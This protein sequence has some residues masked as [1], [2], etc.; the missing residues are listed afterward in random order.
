MLYKQKHIYGSS[1]VGMDVAE[2]NMISTSVTVQSFYCESGKKQYELS[3]HLGNVL[4]VITDKKIPIENSLV[5]GE[6]AYFEA[7][8]LTASD[9]SPFG[10]I[11]ENRDYTSEKY[12]YGF[13]NQERDDELKDNGNS[14][15][16][17]YR[18]HDPRL[19]RFFSVDPVSNEYPYNSC[20]AFSEN[21]VIDG[22]E[23]EGLE[24]VH[25][26][27][28]ISQYATQ[29]LQV[30]KSSEY[31]SSLTFEREDVAERAEKDRI[32]IMDGKLG[33]YGKK[34]QL[35]DI[36]TKAKNLNNTK[37]NSS[38]DLK[39]MQKR[40]NDISSLEEAGISDINMVEKYGGGNKN[41][42]A[43]VLD[44][45]QIKK[46]NKENDFLVDLT[47][48]FM[49]ELIAHYYEKVSSDDNE[50]KDHLKFYGINEKD[51]YKNKFYTKKEIDG[52]LGKYGKSYSPTRYDP[53]SPAGKIYKAIKDA[54]NKINSEKNDNKSPDK[55]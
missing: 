17:T 39:L 28:K 50:V 30:I 23:L 37:N 13:Q 9:Y 33:T 16:F 48:T 18:M 46:L 15:N 19:G 34:V 52:I 2:K 38:I 11:L 36:T 21:R 42:F 26:S 5:S 54:V 22:V 32:L 51:P 12:R 35:I 4:T 55:N 49:H 40:K 44:I 31:L 7:E 8:I 41:T 14:I 29:V 1:R 20:Y 45:E 25:I 53:E 43:I 24:V 6:V 10:T 27:D 47:M 3:N